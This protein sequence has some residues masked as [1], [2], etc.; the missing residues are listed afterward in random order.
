MTG[1]FS[2]QFVG[3]KWLVGFLKVSTHDHMVSG[4][5]SFIRYAIRVSDR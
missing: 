3:S 2:P 4:E 1:S 5:R